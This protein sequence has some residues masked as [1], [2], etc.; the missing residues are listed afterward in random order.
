[1]LCSITF[2][3]P[4][5]GN[6]A[7][8]PHSGRDYSDGWES[9]AGSDSLSWGSP[10]RWGGWSPFGRE[11]SRSKSLFSVADPTA[12]LNNKNNLYNLIPDIFIYLI[13]I[14]HI[15][16]SQVRG[17]LDQKTFNHFISAPRNRGTGHRTEYF[18]QGASRQSFQP[19]FGY[20]FLKSLH[21]TFVF[22]PKSQKFTIHST[23]G[24]IFMSKA[25]SLH[26]Q[27]A[28]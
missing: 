3:S 26:Y 1:M 9:W 12:C 16:N 2:G 19:F 18:G 7:P 22:Y 15:K 27:S 24:K 23:Q 17:S 10:P 20:N 25:G 5:G 8:W 13:W 21:H 28:W 11:V 6:G 4:W 14:R